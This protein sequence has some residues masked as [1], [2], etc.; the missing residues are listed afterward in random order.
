MDIIPFHAPHEFEPNR[1]T[2]KCT[3]LVFDSRTKAVLIC[4]EEEDHWTHIELPRDD[5]RGY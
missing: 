4:G 2:N 1:Y 3:Q 5:P